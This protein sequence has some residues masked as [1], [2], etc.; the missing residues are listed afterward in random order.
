MEAEHYAVDVSAGGEQARA[1]VCEL[2]DDLWRSCAINSTKSPQSPAAAR[3]AFATA[4]C[5]NTLPS[6]SDA[7]NARS[8]TFS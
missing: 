6:D 7:A 8:R 2:D 3:T 1:L 5:A 4:S